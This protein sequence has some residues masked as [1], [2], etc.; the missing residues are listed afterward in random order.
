MTVTVAVTMIVGAGLSSSKTADLL[1]GFLHTP[2]FS[3]H[4]LVHVTA[5]IQ[6]VQPGS[7]FL[8]FLSQT[9][10]LIH[11]Q[12]FVQDCYTNWKPSIWILIIITANICLL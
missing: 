9:T 5:S 7:I 10:R 3:L 4:R 11:H 12:D 2:V 8:A 1:L 6:T